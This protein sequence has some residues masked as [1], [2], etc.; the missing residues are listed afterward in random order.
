[1]GMVTAV[2]SFG[3]SGLYDWLIQRVSAVIMAAYVIFLTGFILFTPEMTYEVWS[4]LY[5]YMTMRIFSLLALA[6]VA[7]HAWI[8]LWSVLTDYITGRLMGAKAMP[9]R[10][11]LQVLMG[12]VVVIYMVWGVEILWGVN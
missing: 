10:L 12:L 8:G 1:M 7:A 5:S 6:S 4:E 11:L 9:L 2:T 3:R